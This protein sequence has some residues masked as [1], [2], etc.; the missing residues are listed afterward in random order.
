[1]YILIVRCSSMYEFGVDCPFNP[2]V[3]SN[4]RFLWH[5]AVGFRQCSFK[6]PLKIWLFQG[7]SSFSKTRSKR[8]HDEQH[9]GFPIISWVLSHFVVSSLVQVVSKCLLDGADEYLQML[10]VCS[11]IMQQASNN[12]WNAT[13]QHLTP[14]R[15]G[16]S[17]ASSRQREDFTQTGRSLFRVVFWTTTSGDHIMVV[18]SVRPELSRCFSLDLIRN[19]LLPLWDKHFNK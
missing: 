4:G 7:S 11:V 5:S 2:Q 15:R 9:V 14:G 6:S 16:P 10:S 1:M 8:Q 12:N 17:S 3:P 13:K 19:G 18:L